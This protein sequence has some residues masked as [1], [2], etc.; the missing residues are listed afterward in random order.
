MKAFQ[1]FIRWMERRYLRKLERFTRNGHLAAAH[2]HTR[3]GLRTA[4]GVGTA[5][6]GAIVAKP[7]AVA[8]S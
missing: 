2:R 5:K 3:R 7:G 8:T 6:S 1:L 4:H